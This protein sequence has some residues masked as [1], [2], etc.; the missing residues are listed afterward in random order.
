MHIC[1]DISLQTQLELTWRHHRYKI[2]FLALIPS[3]VHQLVNYPGIEKVDFSSVTT[4]GSGAAYLPPELGAKMS[5]LIPQDSKFVDGSV[6][7]LF[8]YT[9]IVQ[10]THSKHISNSGRVRHVGSGA[11]VLFRNFVCQNLS[12]YR[13]SLLSC[14]P[15]QGC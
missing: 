15:F 12:M 14:N 8:L 13:H 5:S 1:Y 4:V 3:I 11:C 10:V 2:S 9:F 7:F 6:S